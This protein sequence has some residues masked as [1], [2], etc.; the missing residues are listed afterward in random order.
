MKGPVISIIVPIYKV[1]KYLLRC[2]NSIAAQTYTDF[3]AI[4]I[5]DGSPDRCGEICDEYTIKDARFHVI[6]QENGGLSA[7]R[8]TG[9]NNCRGQY[10]MF[11]D[12]DDYLRIDMCEQLMSAIKMTNADIAVCGF[13]VEEETGRSRRGIGPSCTEII[14][15][16]D[17]V[18]RYFSGSGSTYLANIWNKLYD[19]QI[20]EKHPMI[21]FPVGLKHEDEFTSYKLLYRAKKVA[22]INN[23]LYY[24]V[25]RSDSIMHTLSIDSMMARKACL[26]EYYRWAEEEAPDMKKLIE[27]A[28]IRI[29]N[30]FVWSYVQYGRPS[31]LKAVVNELNVFILGQTKDFWKNPYVNVKQLKNFLLMKAGLL[32]ASK[33]IGR[34]FK[35]QRK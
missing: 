24:Y 16:K 11:V 2:L 17:T 18:I 27:Y 6:H 14:S 21:R 15:G 30:G 20:F 7:A 10:I 8:N 31:E 35:R 34:C 33:V 5:D 22:L 1:E 26:M 23:N 13:W 28:G 19:K 4:L 9:L 32:T 29:F 12:S 3:E 25:Q